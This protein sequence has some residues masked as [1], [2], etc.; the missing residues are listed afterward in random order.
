MPV[1]YGIF[2]LMFV[3]FLLAGHWVEVIYNL[4][5][6]AWYAYSYQKKQWKIDATKVYDNL[7]KLKKIAIGKLIFFL[8]SLFVYL[9][10]M[11]YYLVAEEE[12][13]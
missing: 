7:D 2:A 13:Y 6:L 8:I 5:V 11:V 12:D 1:E 3:L 9:F 10:R 4:P